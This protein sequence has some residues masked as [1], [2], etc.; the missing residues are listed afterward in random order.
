MVATESDF[1]EEQ[2]KKFL[3]KLV[4]SQDHLSVFLPA[5][6]VV[7][8]FVADW[9]FDEFQQNMQKWGFVGEP[10]LDDFVALTEKAKDPQ[11]QEA[12][13]DS[14]L[15]LWR[16]V[17]PGPAQEGRLEWLN[18]PPVPRD[19]AIIGRP[20]LRLLP[21]EPPSPGV[22]VYGQP[23]EPPQ[24]DNIPDPL[25]VT[26]TEGVVANPDGTFQAAESGQIR[27]ER[28]HIVY[29]K[30][31][32][33]VDTTLPEYRDAEFPCDVIVNGDLAGSM[34]WRIFGSLIV[35]GHWSAPN[36]EV[37]GNAVSESGVATGNE[38]VIKIYGNL[39]TSY[40]QFTRMGVSGSLQ[41]DSS[42]VQSEIRVGG[43]IICRGDPGVVMGSE[44][45]CFGALVANKV[46]SDKGRR[47][48]IQIHRRSVNFQPPRTRIA[49]L[50]KDTRMKVYGEIWTQ[51]SDAV[52]ESPLV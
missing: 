12:G 24:G 29:T 20:F 18:E 1:L 48:R 5:G 43:N 25:D 52:Y 45:S 8:E 21:P 41:A 4:V 23:I 37:H 36:I 32:A 38:G 47:T 39:K 33:I 14:E 34:R 15:V 3:S 11:Q 22:S 2:R 42:I 27:L 30:G 50:S 17:A 26:Y 35:K 28:T 51:P 10:S 19:L 46:G 9:T 7:D 16:G 31:Y 40:V 44:V 49:L 6:T 13:I